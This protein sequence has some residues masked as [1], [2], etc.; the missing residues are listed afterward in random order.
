MEIHV[1]KVARLYF[2][3]TSSPEETIFKRLKDGWNKV[4]EIGIDYENL[5]MFDWGKWDG[6]FLAEQAR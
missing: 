5:E 6:T 4:L 3:D 2:G 1:K